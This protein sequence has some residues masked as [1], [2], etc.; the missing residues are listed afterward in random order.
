MVLTDRQIKEAVQRGDIVIEPFE[1]S[2]VQPASYDFRVGAEAAT[3]KSRG[4]IDV[5][6]GN[7][8]T[9]HPGEF[10]FVT[11]REMIGLSPR[12]AA[13]FGLRSRFARLG[14]IATTGPQI[15]PG[16]KG[17]LI[18]GVTNLTAKPIDIEYNADFVSVEFHELSEDVECPYNG[19]YQGI[20]GLGE[21]E[22]DAVKLRDSGLAFS[23]VIDTLMDLQKT[24]GTVDKHVV[25]LG[26]EVRM[27]RWMVP[28]GVG[29]LGIM[30][31]L[32]R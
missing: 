4:K 31:A 16:F 8:F 6:S 1:M 30:I 22:L 19:V 27:L 23:G 7:G 29:I 15:D 9:I 32:L 26:S 12:Y 17:R 24:V 14:L 28:I 25:S 11:V 13:R 3:T 2:Q 10:A 20:T 21:N 18:L 5:Q